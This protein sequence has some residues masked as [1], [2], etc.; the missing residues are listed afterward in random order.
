[1]LYLVEVYDPTRD[2]GRDQYLF[3]F[4]FDESTSRRWSAHHAR[5]I[6]WWIATKLFERD[7]SVVPG[8]TKGM[9]VYL[10]L[11]TEDLR[12]LP[13]SMYPLGEGISVGI[14]HSPDLSPLRQDVMVS[15]RLQMIANE[16]LSQLRA[17]R[18]PPKSR[19]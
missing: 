5:H 12:S 3:Y 4:H 2:I 11:I 6:S 14:G 7:E 13:T 18:G 1:M 19:Y 8:I 15:H 9:R 16:I 17:A 10:K